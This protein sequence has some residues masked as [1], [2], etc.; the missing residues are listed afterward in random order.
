MKLLK[1]LFPDAKIRAIAIA[2]GAMFALAVSLY[3]SGYINQ[4]LAGESFYDFHYPDRFGLLAS[5]KVFFLNR[6]R[7][8]LGHGIFVSIMYELLGY[9]PPAFFLV[10]QF[11]V[12]GTATFI[13]LAIKDFVKDSRLL[14][15]LVVSLT[16]LPLNIH[17]I[18]FLKNAHHVMSWF[19]FWAS[20]YVF[21]TWSRTKLT[22][23]LFVSALLFIASV[24]T[25][26]VSVALLP[27]A[28]F[29]GL[30]YFEKPKQ[31]LRPFLAVVAVTGLAVLLFFVVEYVKP[32]GN[33]NNFYGDIG[34]TKKLL[35]VLSIPS[36]AA[37]GVWNDGLFGLFVSPT[38]LI[39]SAAK[40]FVLGALLVSIFA[41]FRAI[42][43]ERGKIYQA[44]F[45]PP[46]IL[47]MAGLWLAVF[48]A[49]PH[50]FAN[51]GI[52]ADSLRGAAFGLFFF[53]AAAYWWIRQTGR[54]VLA[55]VF[56]ASLSLFWIGI[57]SSSY[58][59]AHQ[60]RVVLEKVI[61]NFVFSLKQEVPYVKENTTFIYVNASLGRTGCIGM[62]NMLYSRDKLQCIHLMDKDA[63][64]SYARLPGMLKEDSG[65]E[66]E[67]D[68]I[69]LTFDE[70]GYATIIDQLSP[71]AYP[72]APIQW[73]DD[74]PILTNTS[75]IM[76]A[77]DPDSRPSLFFDYMLQARTQTD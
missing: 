1:N 3:I 49:L 56:F 10:I 36:N 41:F 40:L 27:V 77:A 59:Q 7:S 11:L 72:T 32:G 37:V 21:I 53:A 74:T 43:K 8:R 42:P 48:G 17:Y 9:N 39:S 31:L 44:L 71:T 4:N 55:S 52:E 64:D 38:P 54:V 14:A 12:I 70:E 35:G 30:Q 13:A 29:L 51:Q 18:V 73:I 2:A 63:P 65:R 61:A 45:T 57:G 24:L 47:L 20:T 62:M 6:I 76:Q 34:A 23:W 60:D 25:Y 26:E 28:F 22:K 67:E 5:I 58:I 75:R 19:T 68:F 50:H 33:I 46:A 66:Y 69:I 15:L 16:L